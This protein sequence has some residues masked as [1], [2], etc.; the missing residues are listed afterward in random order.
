MQKTNDS[1]QKYRGGN[2]E[3]GPWLLAHGPKVL[4]RQFC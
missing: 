1:N 2:P 4:A 3:K